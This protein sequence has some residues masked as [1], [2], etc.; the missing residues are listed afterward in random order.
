[1]KKGGGWGDVFRTSYSLLLPLSFSLCLPNV[2]TNCV[3]GLGWLL[4]IFMLHFVRKNT[5]ARRFS[6]SLSLFLFHSGS[7]FRLFRGILPVDGFGAAENFGL[8]QIAGNLVHRVLDTEKECLK[9][10]LHNLESSV[11]EPEPEQPL[12]CRSRSRSKVVAPVPPIGNI[13][14]LVNINQQFLLNFVNLHVIIT[15]NR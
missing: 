13:A 10:I 7:L 1:M 6:L 12:L 3:W 15:L 9:I 4:L 11:T 2:H 14:K 8:L 5:H